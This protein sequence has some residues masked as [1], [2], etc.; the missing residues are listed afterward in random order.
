MSTSAL[1]AS[2]CA[3]FTSPEASVS[4]PPPFLPPA[5]DIA[6]RETAVFS[7]S[8]AEKDHKSVSSCEGYAWCGLSFRSQ[9]RLLRISHNSRECDCE[10]G[11]KLLEQASGCLQC[12]PGAQR[13]C[14]P[15]SF[16]LRV[17]T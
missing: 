6:A 14:V 13:F 9:N 7:L 16:S 3:M 17:R 8:Q 2:G 12:Q 5:L 15:S 11:Q 4:D 10:P 1:P